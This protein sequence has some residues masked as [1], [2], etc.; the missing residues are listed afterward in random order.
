[1]IHQS[2]DLFLQTAGLKLIIRKSIGEKV[3]QSGK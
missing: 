3:L 1:M 2:A